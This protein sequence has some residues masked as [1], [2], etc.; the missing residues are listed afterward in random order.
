MRRMN[1]KKLTLMSL[2]IA[3]GIVLSFFER[4][5]PVP[6]IVPGAKLG[7]SNVITLMTL[8]FFTR[9]E[10]FAILIARITL[11]ALMFGGVS[12]M[13]YSLFG[14][15]FSFM[16][17]SL[18][19]KVSRDK[20]SFIGV[21]IIGATCHNIGQLTAAALIIQTIRMYSYL[22]LLSITSLFTGFFVGLVVVVL[23]EQKLLYRLKEEI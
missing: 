12:G 17:M 9:K 16:M 5:I 18:V 23:M 7:L 19:L 8:V 22:P 3:M 2:F 1:T 20:L 15:I 14:G 10:A 13:I 21:S 6:F 11:V 4:F